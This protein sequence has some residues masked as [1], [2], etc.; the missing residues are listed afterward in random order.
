MLKPV[1]SMLVNYFMVEAINFI[2]ME[3][4]IQRRLPF[5]LFLETTIVVSTET[6]SFT[7]TSFIDF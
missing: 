3:M 6:A 7:G 5:F 2:W 4:N 1:I